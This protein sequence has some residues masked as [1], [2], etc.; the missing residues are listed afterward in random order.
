[1]YI[2]RA[3]AATPPSPPVSDPRVLGGRGL[4]F[5]PLLLIHH[6]FPSLRTISPLSPSQPHLSF[7]PT[8]LSFPPITL[9]PSVRTLS[10]LS[11]P[12]RL[13][14]YHPIPS[15][16]TLE[17]RTYCRALGRGGLP[18]PRAS[19]SNAGGGGRR[20]D[21]AVPNRGV[22]VPHRARRHDPLDDPRAKRGRREPF[23]LLLSGVRLRSGCK[24][25]SLRFRGGAFWSERSTHLAAS[26][27]FNDPSKRC[28]YESD[29]FH[30]GSRPEIRAKTRHSGL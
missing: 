9:S 18:H 1:M 22:V 12:P 6:P 17:G 5:P 27:G 11:P 28:W 15:L 16:Q 7:S 14:T 26:G 30:P 29:G 20:V 2:D 4:P 3:P 24:A 19:R 8:T 21:H 23:C 13:L 25:R 10:P